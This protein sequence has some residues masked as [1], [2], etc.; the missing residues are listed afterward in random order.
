[1]I[2][3]FPFTPP[4]CPHPKAAPSSLPFACIT[5]L[6]HPPTTPSPLLQHS[7][8]LGHQTSTEPRASL[9]FHVRQ[10]HLL[11]MY[12]ELWIAPYTLLVWWSSPWEY[13]VVWLAYIVLS[14]GLQ[15]SAQFNGWI[16]ASTSVLVSCWQNLPRNCQTRFLSASASWQQQQFW[17]LMSADRMDFQVRRS[18][19]GP[20]S[21]CVFV[22]VCLLLLYP[23][24]YS[25]ISFPSFLSPRFFLSSPP[26]I[27]FYLARDSN[28]AE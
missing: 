24:L 6:T 16:Q 18:P 10:G 28:Q 7:P 20:F 1:M 26:G 19:D 14:M 21:S 23:I 5:L 15:P 11:P 17:G 25:L 3:P 27:T 12:L 8:R 13:L 9:R 22:F 2:S 4:Q